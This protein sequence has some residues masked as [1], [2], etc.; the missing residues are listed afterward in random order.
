MPTRQ[1]H[2]LAFISVVSICAY[3][4][5]FYTSFAKTPTIIFGTANS[6][7]DPSENL[8]NSTQ[9]AVRLQKPALIV[10]EPASEKQR[11]I[12]YIL[13]LTYSDQITGATVNLRCLMCLATELGGVRVVEPLVYGSH[14]GAN[15]SSNWSKQLKLSDLL[16]MV[17]W[18][19]SLSHVGNQFVS[20]EIFLKNSPR[21]IVLVQYCTGLS[22]C[23]PCGY[24]DVVKKAKMFCDLNGFELAG[25]VC[26]SYSHG[27]PL[28]VEAV[29]SQLYSQYKM[30]EVVVMFDLF[31]GIW[32]GKPPSSHDITGYILRMNNGKCATGNVQNIENLV[33]SQLVLSD[34]EKYIQKY[35]N[36]NFSYI[37]VMVRTEFIFRKV[38]V[39]SIESKSSVLKKCLPKL[40]DQ[41]KEMR[42]K[43][44]IN[45][46]FLMMDLGSYGSAAY[47]ENREMWHKLE[48][49]MEVFMSQLF[50]RNTSLL[51]WESTSFHFQKKAFGYIAMVQKVVAAKGKVLIQAGE[52][53]F[54]RSARGLFK[55]FHKGNQVYNNI[56]S[57]L[58]I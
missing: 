44:G 49:Q 18:E 21:K 25:T 42:Q 28:T 45:T 40:L 2:Y 34:A 55:E 10:S 27:L 46:T 47:R 19:R 23:R 54:L 43:T 26:L 11:E 53:T 33:P 3:L 57:M 20:F 30:S 24:E 8:S 36:N 31:G 4:Y 50:G 51:E 15:A 9:V 29:R 17:V 5:I 52:G 48:K 32:M 12:G 22:A 56:L 1:C 38:K 16:D 35:L 6:F 13:A 58:C 41:V 39:K 14:L 7:Y 37:S